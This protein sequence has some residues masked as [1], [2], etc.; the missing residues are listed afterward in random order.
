MIV[1]CS[2]CNELFSD[3]NFDSHICDLPLNGVRRIEVVYFRDDSYKDK[4]LMTGWGIDGI[5]Y[6]FEVVP[7][8]Q[9]SII[10]PLAD[11]KKHLNGTDGEVTEPTQRFCKV[12]V[13]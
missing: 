7:R 4:K 8:K 5:T 13:C 12:C 2:H 9:I 3:E 10:M 1:K 6:T 11:E